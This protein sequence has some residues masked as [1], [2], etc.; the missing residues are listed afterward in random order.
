MHLLHKSVVSAVEME[1]F[2][3]SGEDE[4][5]GQ[6]GAI[7]TQWNWNMDFTVEYDIIVFLN[8]LYMFIV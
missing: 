6:G 5:A 8:K 7:D 3:A 1:N 4:R 2:L